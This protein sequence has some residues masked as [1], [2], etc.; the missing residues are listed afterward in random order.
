MNKSYTIV[1][2]NNN[3]VATYGT[4]KEAEKRVRTLDPETQDK[5]V[6]RYMANNGY[7]TYAEFYKYHKDTDFS[8]YKIIETTLS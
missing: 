6:E 3:V 7:F 8:D 2:P 5:K 1:D 4:R